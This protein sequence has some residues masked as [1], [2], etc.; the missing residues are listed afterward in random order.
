MSLWQCKDVH[1]SSCNCIY[2]QIRVMPDCN[3]IMDKNVNSVRLQYIKINKK[4]PNQKFYIELF[5]GT[6]KKPH[7]CLM[8]EVKIVVVCVTTRDFNSLVKITH[9]FLSSKVKRFSLFFSLKSFS[10]DC[11]SLLF[12]FIIL[13]F[14]FFLLSFQ[15]LEV[16]GLW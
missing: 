12:K 16:L 5:L 15:W 14:L 6:Q 11:L 10:N 8:E 1:S 3:L 2:F 13:C 4:I 7:S 9:L